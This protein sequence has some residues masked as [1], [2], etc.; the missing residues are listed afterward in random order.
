MSESQR[1]TKVRIVGDPDLAR[2]VA[3]A[4]ELNFELYAKTFYNK[5]VGRDYAH[6]NADGLTIYLG[7][8]KHKEIFKESQVLPCGCILRN[9]TFLIPCET[10][11]K[12]AR[13]NAQNI[14]CCGGC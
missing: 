13:A 10:H 1:K 8:K 6:T 11:L 9:Q 7:I 3:T 12:Q 14:V 2:E 5:A 4:V